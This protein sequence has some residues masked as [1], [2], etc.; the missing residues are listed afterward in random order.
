MI[1]AAFIGASVAAVFALM[2]SLI[3]YPNAV[4]SPF[5]RTLHD[6]LGLP[7]D[8][9]PSRRGPHRHG[10]TPRQVGRAVA[11]VE[12]AALLGEDI[13]ELPIA[14]LVFDCFDNASMAASKRHGRP[15]TV[16]QILAELQRYTLLRGLSKPG[17]NWLKVCRWAAQSGEVREAEK[18]RAYES[19]RTAQRRVD[20][21]LRFLPKSERD[22]YRREWEAEAGVME[23]AVAAQYG[24]NVLIRAPKAGLTLR[25]SKIFG[26]QA[27]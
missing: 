8:I 15:P 25:L 16:E 23:P 22:H 24:F 17:F 26:R 13:A 1:E 6:F 11:Q 20:L 14:K 10:Q 5:I 12:R 4:M 3:A 2:L 7:S 27:A 18:L 21:A 19:F 9:G